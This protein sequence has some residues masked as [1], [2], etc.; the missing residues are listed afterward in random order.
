MGKKVD[1]TYFGA[2]LLMVQSDFE[3]ISRNKDEI[4]QN[5]I[6]LGFIC[7][8]FT[9]AATAAT[10]FWEKKETNYT[11]YFD[12]SFTQSLFYDLQTPRLG[13]QITNVEW[14]WFDFENNFD[15]QTVDLCYRKPNTSSDFT[16]LDISSNPVG[17]TGH[18]NGFD[19]RGTTVLR[20]T[21]TGSTYFAH[22]DNNVLN[23]IKVTYDY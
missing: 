19:A 4:Y 17:S 6:S 8:F 23:T 9:T 10:G 22:W 21:L 20:Y 11:I 1:C 14:E 13:T 7:T 3:R 18:F 2:Y 5:V 16:C 12:G 15:T